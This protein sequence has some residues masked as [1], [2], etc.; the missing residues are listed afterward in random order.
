MSTSL[1]YALPLS[2]LVVFKLM[3]GAFTGFDSFRSSGLIE[4]F[5][6]PL[7]FVIAV[8]MT[9][10]SL[11]TEKTSRLQVKKR[12]ARHY[13]RKQKRERAILTIDCFWRCC[14]HRNPCV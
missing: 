8:Q 13:P 12:P 5:A 11:V 14:A 4:A 2:S 10:V 3:Y 7:M 6:A 9:A 1:Y